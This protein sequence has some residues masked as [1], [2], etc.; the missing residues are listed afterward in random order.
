MPEL[1]N[2]TDSKDLELLV[3]CRFPGPLSTYWI[4]ISRGD[5]NLEYCNQRTM[6]SESQISYL[7][8]LRRHTISL[9]L[10]HTCNS[11]HKIVEMT[12]EWGGPAGRWGREGLLA[13]VDGELT[14]GV[15]GPGNLRLEEAPEGK[16]QNSGLLVTSGSSTTIILSHW[17]KH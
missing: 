13:E 2:H 15:E 6:C 17:G 3:K 7:Q 14:V 1:S 8:T 9:H 12:Q 16:E 5:I 11:T 4:R 10:A